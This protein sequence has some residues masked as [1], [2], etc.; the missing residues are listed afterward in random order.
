VESS[1]NEQRLGASATLTGIRRRRHDVDIWVPA[2]LATSRDEYGIHDS[3]HVL[4]PESGQVVL[5]EAALKPLHLA[6]IDAPG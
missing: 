5:L 2:L 1:V 6:F 3:I 4:A